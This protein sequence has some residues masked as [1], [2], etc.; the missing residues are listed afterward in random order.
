MINHHIWL[1]SGSEAGAE[2]TKR[3][4]G[5][6]AVIQ[7]ERVLNAFRVQDSTPANVEI[8]LRGIARHSSSVF[9]WSVQQ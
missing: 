6:T 3:V 1:V 8:N 2:I 4:R 7:R 9:L 5:K